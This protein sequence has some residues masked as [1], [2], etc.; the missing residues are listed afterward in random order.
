M[1]A[2]YH[3]FSLALLF[4]MSVAYVS[5]KILF[6]SLKSTVKRGDIDTKHTFISKEGAML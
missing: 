4:R 3:R 1:D 6:D 5:V 2:L